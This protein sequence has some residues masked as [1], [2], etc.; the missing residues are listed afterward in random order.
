MVYKRNV[1][2]KKNE[3]YSKHTKDLFTGGM[4]LSLG[5]GVVEKLPASA[6]KTGV[7]QGLG[8]AGGFFPTIAT[9]GAAGIVVKQLRKIKK[10][11]RRNKK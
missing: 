7:Q 11:E 5:A 3:D 1:S 10:T 6:A 2:K 4:G 8:T 9:V